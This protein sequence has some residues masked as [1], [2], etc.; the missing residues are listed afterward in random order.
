MRGTAALAWVVCEK[1]RP[2][3]SWVIRTFGENVKPSTGGVSI[4]LITFTLLRDSQWLH[5]AHQR[6]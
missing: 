5:E 4:E 6:N 2:L 1:W 3:K